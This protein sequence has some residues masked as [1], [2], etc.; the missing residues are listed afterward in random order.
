VRIFKKA[1]LAALARA[2]YGVH[3]I[4]AQRSN[5]TYDPTK[6]RPVPIDWRVVPA[7]NKFYDP[8]S[9]GIYTLATET[10]IPR[11]QAPRE[12]TL[13]FDRER[14]RARH[15]AFKYPQGRLPR[16][17]YTLALGW[18]G[19][20]SGL[21]LEACT[22]NPR[23]D[24]RAAVASLG[25]SYQAIDIH[26]GHPDVKR[27]DL[28]KLSLP[29][30]SVARILSC[31]T[32]EHI[33]NYQTALGEMH[34]VLQDHGNAI[35]HIPCR[36]FDRAEGEPIKPGIDATGHVYY[37]AAR[38]FLSEAT[39]VG[40]VVPRVAFILD[41]SSLLAVLVKAPRLAI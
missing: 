12:P 6:F 32:L 22:G 20:G 10:V 27:E 31:D 3:K 4:T 25:Y 38:E 30:A 19:P 33:E 29:T 16:D 11:P 34:R 39:K 7:N 1:V 21:L 35:V 37:H 15:Y 28:T 13:D 41:P 24:V 9:E 17:R 18:L 2:G 26:P 5:P 8:N 36:W 14:E 23:D 40:F